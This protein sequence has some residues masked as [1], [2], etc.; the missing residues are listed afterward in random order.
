MYQANP[1]EMFRERQLGLLRE[2]EGRRL[3]RRLRKARSEGT[4][5]GYPCL[6]TTFSRRVR[7]GMR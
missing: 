5:A 4:S 3:V 2:T 1:A 6:R 7:L